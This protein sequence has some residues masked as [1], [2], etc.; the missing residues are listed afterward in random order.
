[1][2]FVPGIRLHAG[3]LKAKF[4]AEIP[5]TKNDDFR[6]SQNAPTADWRIIGGLSLQFSL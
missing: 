6:L 2:T 3:P 5:V 1:M 4:G